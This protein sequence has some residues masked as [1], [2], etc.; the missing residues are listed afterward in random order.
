LAPRRTLGHIGSS[1]SLRSNPP[2]EFA[3][4]AIEKRGDE[5]DAQPARQV[6]RKKNGGPKHAVYKQLNVRE[7]VLRRRQNRNRASD[8]I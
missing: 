8:F 7:L 1:C 4:T 2:S 6:A 3:A 5:R